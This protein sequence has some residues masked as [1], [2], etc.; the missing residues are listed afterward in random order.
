M[1][2]THAPHLQSS[3]EYD[4]LQ[5]LYAYRILD[6]PFGPEFEEIVRA[7]AGICQT[8]ISA[9]SLIDADIQWFKVGYGLDVDHAERRLTFCNHTLCGD[10]LFMVPD[11]SQDERFAE[12]PFVQGDAHMRFYAGVPL[13]TDAGHTLGTLCVIDH[14][15]RA[16]TEI[17]TTALALLARQAMT[18]LDLQRQREQLRQH[19]DFLESLD[20]ARRMQESSLPDLAAVHAF[21]NSFTLYQPRQTVG[22][23]F[24][25]AYKGNLAQVL[26]VGSCSGTGLS[27]ALLSLMA[28]SMLEGMVRAEEVP[29]PHIL[30]R[31]FSQ[32]WQ[33]R[34]VQRPFLHQEQ[35]SLG[36]LVHDPFRRMVSFAG[37]GSDLYLVQEGRVEC[38]R[39]EREPI[40]RGA[41]DRYFTQISLDKAQNP[42]L[43]LASDGILRQQSP[44]GEAFGDARF[45][46]ML[47]EVSTL[48]IHEQRTQ[49]VT[50]LNAWR[51][52]QEQTDDICLIGLK[53]R[54]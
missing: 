47:A 2:I 41:S 16:L 24:Y 14:E 51:G 15:A 43:Y 1:S 36:A 38:I 52:T 29:G 12:N 8:P 35:L 6:K 3:T 25:W 22:G 10:S 20:F 7:A 40:G 21:E 48:P 19:N 9:L 42:T 4:R 37:A 23:D 54:S 18:L 26:T 11:L 49:V 28:D 32:A 39:G 50:L 45:R 44:S 27:G 13:R 33:H 31:Q 5:E 46:S 30:L 53:L 34:A 17:Q